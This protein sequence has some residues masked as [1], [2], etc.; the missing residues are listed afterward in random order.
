MTSLHTWKMLR[1]AALLTFA[2]AIPT[3]A[4]VFTTIASFTSMNGANV[5]LVQGTDGNF[6]G[7]QPT[8]P[9]SVFRVAP[10]GDITELYEFDTSGYSPLAGL[11]LATD[12]GFYGTTSN[13]AAH[14]S[15]IF[16]IASDGAFTTLYDFCPTKYPFCPNGVSPVAALLQ[17]DSG[18]IYGTTELGG[19][20]TCN[21]PYGCGTVFKITLGGSLT[22]LHKFDF[23]RDFATLIWPQFGR[24]IWP[25]L[26]YS[27]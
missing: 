17:A 25:H 8:Y 13:S 23:S 3:P 27:D 6:Y 21:G 15:A 26:I 4:Q 14:G 24:L 20:L 16:S 7:T 11:V 2:A 19:D 18:P 1:L 22:T 5:S 10:T 12:G 9:G